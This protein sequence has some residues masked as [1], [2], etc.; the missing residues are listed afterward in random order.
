MKI[1]KKTLTIVM[2]RTF[3]KATMVRTH[4]VAPERLKEE[5]G[6]GPPQRR[7]PSIVRGRQ[8]GTAQPVVSKGRYTSKDKL[9]MSETRPVKRSR[10]V[11]AGPHLHDLPSEVIW[12]CMWC[13]SIRDLVALASV[14]RRCR[15]LYALMF[16]SRDFAER[17][18]EYID[19]CEPRALVRFAK[20]FSAAYAVH[21]G[22]GRYLRDQH[23]VAHVYATPSDGDSTLVV[24]V[25]RFERN[26][27]TR[28]CKGSFTMHVCCNENAATDTV[29]VL[30]DIVLDVAADCQRNIDIAVRRTE[31]YNEDHA[32]E[33]ERLA[34]YKEHPHE[35]RIWV[36]PRIHYR[37]D[38][39]AWT[40]LRA[41]RW[42][43][44]QEPVL[45]DDFLAYASRYCAFTLY[46]QHI[47]HNDNEGGSYLLHN[48][49]CTVY[50]MQKAGPYGWGVAVTPARSSDDLPRETNGAAL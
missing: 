33:I 10:H 18:N 4:Q 23:L 45:V 34:T 29:T 14:D 40:L 32:D 27:E 1:T 20:H 28:V 38:Q 21:T 5:R 15:A 25:G 13:V 47:R 50:E 24:S 41:S 7:S 46:N 35:M 9:G 31:L 8:G 48:L 37:H 44:N 42:H 43:K 3:G 39:T 2:Q 26:A 49:L 36:R 11:H 19:A 12:A 30:M 22:G 17:V 16:R 6:F